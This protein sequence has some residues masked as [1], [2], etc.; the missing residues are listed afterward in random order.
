MPVLVA[1]ALRES[2]PAAGLVLVATL[3]GVGIASRFGLGR[4]HLLLV[5]RLSVLM[6]LVVLTVTGLALL[7][8]ALDAG[9]LAWGVLL[10][11]VILT[12]LIE[13]VTVTLAEEGGRNTLVKGAW[14]LVVVLTCYPLFAS[15]FL[16]QLL[17]GYPEL[18]VVIM[19][20]LVW[21]GGYMGYR[22]SELVRFRNA[23]GVGAAP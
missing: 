18:I 2:S 15:P 1:L 20:L 7:G 17:F 8:R 14:S 10:P 16:A 22:L 12:M 9:D 11:M 13:R 4:L 5:P 19:G 3:I 6:C 23:P 21:I